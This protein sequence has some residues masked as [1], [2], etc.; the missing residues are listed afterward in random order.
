MEGDT[1]VLFE[2]KPLDWS[3]S[4][5]AALPDGITQTLASLLQIISFKETKVAHVW[6]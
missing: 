6:A 4:R 3:N 1:V 2:V 5:T